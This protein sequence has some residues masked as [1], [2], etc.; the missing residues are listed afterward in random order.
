M[1]GLFIKRNLVWKKRREAWWRKLQK[2]LLIHLKDDEQSIVISSLEIVII[3]L[4][5]S[6]L[7]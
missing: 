2:R 4:I 3:S 1:K 7:E 5:D 6:V